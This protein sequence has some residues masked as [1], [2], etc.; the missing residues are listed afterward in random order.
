MHYAICIIHNQNNRVNTEDGMTVFENSKNR[1]FGE[2]LHNKNINEK[3]KTE[4]KPNPNIKI[5]Q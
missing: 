5:I 3:N 4:R 2:K 1:L